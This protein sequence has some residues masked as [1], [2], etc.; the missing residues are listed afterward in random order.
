MFELR[1][2]FSTIPRRLSPH[3]LTHTRT[4]IKN[5][6][7]RCLITLNETFGVVLRK[8]MITR[9]RVVSPCRS[10]IV[11]LLIDVIQTMKSFNNVNVFQR[12]HD[13]TTKLCLCVHDETGIYTWQK[14]RL[15]FCLLA[16]DWWLSG[17]REFTWGSTGWVIRL[18]ADWPAASWRT[19][20]ADE[21][22]RTNRCCVLY[23]RPCLARGERI[24]ASFSTFLPSFAGLRAFRRSGTQCFVAS[25]DDLVARFT[26]KYIT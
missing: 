10:T 22:T 5:K 1:E 21:G 18:D 15:P 8:A 14:W 19:R 23:V 24:A 17:T 3:H 16:G 2:I 4:T 7:S 12:K 6:S 26:R 20:F 9:E 25:Y 13:T 11:N